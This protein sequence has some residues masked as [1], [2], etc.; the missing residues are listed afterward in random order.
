[1]Q[2]QYFDLLLLLLFQRIP[3]NILSN[4]SLLY[5]EHLYSFLRPWLG[6]GF[7]TAA[8]ARWLKHRQIYAPAFEQKEIDGYLQVVHQASKRLMEKLAQRATSAADG[9]PK[10]LDVQPLLGKCTLDIAVGKF[11]LFN[12][13]RL[14]SE[15]H[16]CN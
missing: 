13:E 7:V 4:S 5:K 2:L 14:P 11:R 15:L 12:L 8:A 16:N 10:V 1:M 6:D 3:L 9:V